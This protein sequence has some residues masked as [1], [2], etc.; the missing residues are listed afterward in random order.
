[1]RQ[2]AVALSTAGENPHGESWLKTKTGKFGANKKIFEK[3]F[4]GGILINRFFPA[5][6]SSDGETIEGRGSAQS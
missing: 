2:F 3:K 4:Q 1:M 6:H 5:S